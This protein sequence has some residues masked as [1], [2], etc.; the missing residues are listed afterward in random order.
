MS[1]RPPKVFGYGRA[2]TKKQVE[3]PE[4]QKDMIKKYAVFHSLGDVTFFVD[5]AKSGKIAWEDRDAGK[6]LFKPLHDRAFL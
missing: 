1:D 6:A 4:T 3:S 5:A 2:S